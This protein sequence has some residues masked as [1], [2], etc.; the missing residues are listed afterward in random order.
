MYFFVTCLALILLVLIPVAR[1]IKSSFIFSH[2]FCDLKHLNL[3]QRLCHIQ[4]L[5]PEGTSDCRKKAVESDTK[6]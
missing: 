4:A 3:M 2:D 6:I 1:G 5:L